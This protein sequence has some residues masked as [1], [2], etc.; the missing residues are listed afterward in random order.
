MGWVG[1]S[2]ACK[3]VCSLS[4]IGIFSGSKFFLLMNRMETTLTDPSYVRSF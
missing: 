4:L 3:E 1:T 2:A